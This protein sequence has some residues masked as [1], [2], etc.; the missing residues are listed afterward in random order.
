MDGIGKSFA[1]GFGCS[2][3]AGGEGANVA[4][5]TM[6][7]VITTKDVVVNLGLIWREFGITCVFRCLYAVVKRQETTF[8]DVALGNEAERRQGPV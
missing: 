5:I 2:E 3:S 1:F 4:R 7:G 8:L 6:R